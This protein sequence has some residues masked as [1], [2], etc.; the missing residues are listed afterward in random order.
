MDLDYA[1]SKVLD[2]TGSLAPK[3]SGGFYVKVT[4]H[5]NIENQ[6]RIV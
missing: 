2:W 4:R 3:A 1:Y 5:V 6:Y